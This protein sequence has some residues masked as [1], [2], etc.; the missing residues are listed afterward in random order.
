MVQVIQ[1]DTLSAY[2]ELDTDQKLT[3][4]IARVSLLCAQGLDGKAA[5]LDIDLSLQ[6]LDIWAKRIKQRTDEH[7]HLFHANPEPYDHCEPIWRM[8]AMARVLNQEYGIT[9][10]PDRINGQPDWADA[11]DLLLHGLLGSRRT[12]TCITLPVLVVAI[13]R[14]L[15]Y[16]LYLSHA[17]AHCFSRWD[18]TRDDI[19][20]PRAW[21]HRF[22]IE[23]HGHIDFHPDERY[24]DF[25]VKWPDWQ[26]KQHQMGDP[27]CQYLNTFTP[28]Q[29]HA[30]SICQR[31]IVLEE[32]G[33]FNESIHCYLTAHELDGCYKG[34]RH[35]AWRAMRNKAE[36]IMPQMGYPA[37]VF[38]TWLVQS[39]LVCAEDAQ[40]TMPQAF[41]VAPTN[42][43][44]LIRHVLD[45]VC[46]G[47]PIPPTIDLLL[48]NPPELQVDPYANQNKQNTQLKLTPVTMK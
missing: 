7:I 40:V 31:A 37:Q 35:F 32:T 12:G 19:N 46:K 39:G 28:L 10:N 25:P 5:D 29:E 47:T 20:V 3:I 4:D 21:Q 23:F 6:R 36:T 2:L 8:L 14:R 33:Q 30:S 15:G 42:M 13:G 9:Y 17:P 41:G 48:P 44:D 26:R 18:G 24:Y 38:R 45:M 43:P 34:Y 16:P 11:Q 22:N 1:P 27:N